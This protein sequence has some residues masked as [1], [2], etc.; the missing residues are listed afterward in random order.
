M[1]VELIVDPRLRH[2]IDFTRKIIASPAMNQSDPLIAIVNVYRPTLE[3]ELIPAPDAL[4]F[5]IADV[6]LFHALDE[7]ILHHSGGDLSLP[8]AIAAVHVA[9]GVIHAARTLDDDGAGE[10]AAPVPFHPPEM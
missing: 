10:R 3:D 2:I 8:Q 5:E 1:G 9:F 6:D 4:A 7:I